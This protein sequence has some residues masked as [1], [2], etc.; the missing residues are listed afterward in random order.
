MLGTSRNYPPDPST[1][2]GH[3]GMVARNDMHVQAEHGLPRCGAHVYADVV[4]V[5]MVLALGEHLAVVDEPGDG[6]SLIVGRIEVTCHMPERDDEL[7]AG[8]DRVDIVAGIAE[9]VLRHDILRGRV[10][11]RASR[12][13]FSSPDYS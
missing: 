2:V 9:V 4:A 8:A 1:G 7:V 6:H 5:W 11:E 12:G 13:S 3:V 10:A